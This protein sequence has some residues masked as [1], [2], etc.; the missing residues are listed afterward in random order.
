MRQIMECV[1]HLHEKGLV[2][3]DIK[4]LNVVRLGLDNRLRLIDLDAARKI[5]SRPWLGDY[6]CAKFSSAILPPKCF[7]KLD[8]DQQKQFESYFEGVDAEL[9]EK[10]ALEGRQARRVVRRQDVL[11][12][13]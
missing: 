1:Q 9:R 12:H 5:S 10:V 3:G 7:A 13:R 4:M 11:A 6:V 2:H 8:A